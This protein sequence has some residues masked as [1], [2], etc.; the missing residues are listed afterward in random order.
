M[1]IQNSYIF[2]QNPYKKKE[3]PKEK[4]GDGISIDFK[5]KFISYF[6][7]VFPSARTDQDMYYI[8]LEYTYEVELDG[9]RLDARFLIHEVDETYYLDVVICG[10]SKAQIIGGLEYIQKVIDES[11]IPKHYIVIISY[12]AISE[13]YWNKIYPKLNELERN[14]RKLLFNIYVVN[15]GPA[16]YQTTISNDLQNQVKKN[17]QAKGNAENIATERLKKFFYSMEFA[18]IQQMLFVSQWS[19]VDE[20]AK[21]AFLRKHKDLSKLT[22]GELRKEFSEIAPKSDWERFFADK[23]DADVIQSLINEI[24]KS[25]NNIAHCKFFYKAEFKSC[26]KAM[27]RFNNAVNSAIATT[28]HK[29]FAKKSHETFISAFSG[30][31]ALIE[32]Y[33][34]IIKKALNPAIQLSQQFN[35]MLVPIREDL[36]RNASM[37]QE[38]FQPTKQFLEALREIIPTISSSSDLIYDPKSSTNNASKDDENGQVGQNED[39]TE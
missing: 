6:E 25:R 12:D 7:S 14:L 33:N 9:N 37:L 2:M 17:I 31:K 22:D 18:Q 39:D 1:R 30:F 5:H 4:V 20:K 19:E 16:Y 28:E 21:A 24:R 27:D 32:D 29:D 13:Y 36:A 10:S 34:T 15:F 35:E 3:P 23:M 26:S 11:V 8:T 38:A